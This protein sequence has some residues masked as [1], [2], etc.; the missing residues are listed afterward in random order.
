M[1]V[2]SWL[3]ADSALRVRL[4]T[5]LLVEALL[6]FGGIFKFMMSCL[7]IGE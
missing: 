2:D 3:G 1:G 4:S 6:R 7:S 5:L